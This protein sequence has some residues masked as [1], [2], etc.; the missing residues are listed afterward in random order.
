MRMK[1]KKGKNNS[2]PKGNEKTLK[3]V[4]YFDFMCPWSYLT[5]ARVKKALAHTHTN[6][7]MEW[8]PFELYEGNFDHRVERKSIYGHESL[9]AVYADLRNLGLREHL[10][11]HHPRY[12]GS[13]R[14]A[15]T[16]YLFAR[17]KGMGEKYLDV[18]FEQVFEHVNDISSLTVLSRIAVKLGFDVNAFMAFVESPS[19]QS[20]IHTLTLAAKHN[21][22]KGLPTYLI[23]G[24]LIQGALPVSEWESLFRMHT[25]HPVPMMRAVEKEKK[26][27]PKAA[28]K[29]SPPK[30]APQPRPKKWKKSRKR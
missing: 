5:R 11:I 17:R 8:I 24:T 21:G 23:N 7:S 25:H 9:N 6:A 20:Q 18:M 15:L 16:G 10:I 13:S 28:K 22:I 2:T 27:T 19:N 12:E 14:R 3:I 30:K 29:K 1:T 26:K 4:A